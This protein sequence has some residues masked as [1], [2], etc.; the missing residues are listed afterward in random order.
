MFESAVAFAMK[1]FL[2][3]VQWA[4]AIFNA[5]GGFGFYVGMFSLFVIY[6]LLI[7]PL[8]GHDAGSDRAVAKTIVNSG[9]TSYKEDIE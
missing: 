2:T 1:I 9:K 8:I 3:P 4:T 7:V 6:R 5:T